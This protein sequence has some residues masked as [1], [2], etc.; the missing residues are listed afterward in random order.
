MDDDDFE[1]DKAK[2]RLNLQKHA[3]SFEVAREVFEDLFAHEWADE[4]EDYGEER[5][6]ITGL[7]RRR[8]IAATYTISE[9]EMRIISARKA[10]PRERRR[11]HDQKD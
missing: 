11:Y 6:N 2:A 9:T 7:V 10:E 1:W 3:L 4:R 8:L 5:F